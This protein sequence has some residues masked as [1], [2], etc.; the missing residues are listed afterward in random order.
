MIPVKRAQAKPADRTQNRRRP[1]VA[2]ELPPP[3]GAHAA[4]HLTNED[5]TPGAG[6]LTSMTRG[7]SRYVDGGAG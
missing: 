2:S 4:A 5:A 6:A 3:A 1:P 7:S